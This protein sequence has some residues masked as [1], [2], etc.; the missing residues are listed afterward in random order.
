MPRGTSE[1]KNSDSPFEPRPSFSSLFPLPS[2]QLPTLT[3][4][5]S[6]PNPPDTASSFSSSSPSSFSDTRFLIRIHTR[7]R[8]CRTTNDEIVTSFSTLTEKKEEVAEVSRAEIPTTGWTAKR[9]KGL[10][11]GT[12]IDQ[13]LP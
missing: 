13:I 8:R 1:E 2:F 11:Q 3:P 9:M 6:R 7:Y 5:S 12:F 4:F 10:N